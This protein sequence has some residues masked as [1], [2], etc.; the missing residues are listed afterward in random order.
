MDPR[1]PNFWIFCQRMKQQANTKHQMIPE[2]KAVHGPDLVWFHS[3]GRCC[4]S[5]ILP[6]RSNGLA[7]LNNAKMLDLVTPG[8]RSS[9]RPQTLKITALCSGLKRTWRLSPKKSWSFRLDTVGG[10]P[11]PQSQLS[12]LITP[13]AMI[14][15]WYIYTYMVMVQN[16]VPLMNI[17]I[18]GK[19][20]FIHPNMVPLVLTH[21]HMVHKPTNNWGGTTLYGPVA[22]LQ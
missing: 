10:A 4:K 1:G 22:H 11:E 18:A 19:W 15:G 14:Y 17:K 9:L 12:W 3:V 16:P 6:S 7:Y 8:H 13:I 5:L 2:E 20:M 21:G